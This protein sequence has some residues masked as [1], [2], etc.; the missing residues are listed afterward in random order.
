M[1]GYLDMRCIL[2]LPLILLA[3]CVTTEVLQADA[4][5][6]IGPYEE[7]S[8]R[9]QSYAHYLTALVHERGH[10]Y[11]EAV[12]EMRQASELAPEAVVP[13][14]K[15]TQAYLRMQ[16]FD[17]ARIMCERAVK[18]LPDNPNLWVML[19]EIHHQL[20]QYDQAVAAF[21][22][23]IALDPESKLGYDALIAVGEATNDLVA[24]VDIYRRIIKTRPNDANLHY[25][26]G[27]NLARMND[28]QGAAEALEKALELN[29]SLPRARFVLGLVYF[30]SDR[31]EPAREEFKKVLSQEPENVRAREHLVGTLGRLGDYDGALRQLKEILARGG[32]EPR[33]LIE[34]SYLLLRAE[35]YEDASKVPPP[36][37]GPV[38]GMILN[39][40]ARKCLGLPYE[41]LYKSLDSVETDVDAECQAFL[42]ELIYLFGEEDTGHYL[43]D[44]LD[45]DTRSKTVETVRA[46]ILI[47]L[48][49]YEEAETTLLRILET[50]PPDKHIHYYLA[51]VYE[52]LDDFNATEKHLLAYI[53]MEPDDPDILNFLGYLYA[54]HKVKLDEAEI[55]LRRALEMDP[56]NG[57]Y[58]DS[59]GWI[60]YARGDAPK[61]IEFI[62]QAILAMDN[63]DAELRDH[64]GD[65]YLLN[66]EV[67]RA[68]AEWERARRLDPTYEGVQE[69]IDQHR[70]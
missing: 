33:Y 69:K 57:F 37:G 28:A 22:K 30:E 32:Q 52:E 39:A 20:Q 42:S 50:F 27:L 11:D 55:L 23:A 48:E 3:G 41:L 2:S 59:L 61:A 66:G 13:T 9:A 43:L 58:L 19:G 31:N 47:A 21:E 18:Q 36:K 15:L 26:L 56:N 4:Q 60:Y 24:A 14:L 53:A 7:P 8:V 64:L 44:A 46:R 40:A 68:V 16:D 1:K 34:L 12:A 17:N 38:F 67:D 5:D 70:E 49:R 6:A 62:R 35:R 51:T 29:P 45:A 65:A 63:D 25:Q 54:V 10:R